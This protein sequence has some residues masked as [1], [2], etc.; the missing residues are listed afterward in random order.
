VKAR[1]L[2]LIALVLL[3]LIPSLILQAVYGP[4]YGFFSGEDRWI[5][6]GTGGWVMRG[7]PTEPMPT[8]PSKDIP[9]LLPYLPIFLPAFLLILFLF[10]PL[11]RKLEIPQS[12]PTDGAGELPKE[13]P[14]PDDTDKPSSDRL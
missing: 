5:P 9:L 7:Q 11:T 13:A 4:S 8:E 2:L 14:P 6:D 3:Y 1:A 12:K 10:T